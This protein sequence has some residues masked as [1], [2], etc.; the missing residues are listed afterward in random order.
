MLQNKFLNF[1]FL[2]LNLV[3]VFFLY[4]R[5]IRHIKIIQII[6]RAKKFFWKTKLPT[7]KI[8]F[9]IKVRKKNVHLQ[10][11]SK[12]ES[13][14][15]NNEFKFL[16][17]LKKL[18]FPD[19]WIPLKTPLLWIYN[20]HY[21]DG[22]L[23]KKTSKSLKRNLVDKW[24]HDNSV[25]KS[26]AWDPY[27]LSVRICNWIKWFWQDENN[28]SSLRLSSLIQQVKHLENNLEY[29][30]LGNH[31]LENARA[32]IFAGYFLEE[33]F[34]EKWLLLGLNILKKQL[35]EQILEDGGHFE[36]S[37][38]YHCI[39]LELVLDILQLARDKKSPLA[40]QF[41]TNYLQ[42][43]ATKMCNWLSVMT[44]PDKDISFFNDSAL[45]LAPKP[46]DLFKY[47]QK[48]CGINTSYKFE[49]VEYLKSS[50]YIRLTNQN[51]TLFFDVA[52]IGASYIPG[53]GHADTLSLEFSLFKQRVIVNTGISEY[54]NGPRR[55]YER[56]TAAHS[57]VEI[58]KK[59]SSEV[60][61]GFRVGRKAKVEKVLFLN[62]LSVKAEHNG[63]RFL[64]KKTNHVRKITLKYNNLFVEDLIT[65]N[66]YNFTT[67]YHLHPNV[68]I[69]IS[70]SKKKGIIILKNNK[71]IN[72]ECEATK[73]HIEKD[74]YAESFGKI[75][76][77]NTLVLQQNNG[78]K[79]K[80]KLSWS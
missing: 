74:Y 27:P 34:G 70:K 48:V 75:L 79:T 55:Q 72:W 66:K 28:I 10:F 76:Y 68:K 3:K 57:T 51:S 4:W 23:E 77:T 62:N 69:V 80:L 60:W 73:C 11:L 54:G 43:I 64:S 50:G 35:K 1:S 24:I 26:V 5:T 49:G 8:N 78:K 39:M 22:L 16:N 58:D 59:N 36:L 30:L 33:D 37:P 71:L 56:S 63:Y 14:F 7:L 32:L 44:H 42:N 20:L 9:N 18:D 40:L 46:H 6:Y 53:H 12:K 47:A 2:I 38:M 17:E 19:G 41:Q 45:N 65:D 31:L 15:P 61:S 67:R 29:H 25:K 21:F 52:E 13:I